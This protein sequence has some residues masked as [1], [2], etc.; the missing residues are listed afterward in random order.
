MVRNKNTESTMTGS[1]IETL[2]E[3]LHARQVPSNRPLVTLS[4][5][6]SLD[7]S[8]TVKPGRP[9]ALSGEHSLKL[10]HRLRAYH[11]GILIGIGTVL[12][13]NPRLDVRLVEG[14]DPQPI[15]MD[16]RLRTPLACN[17]LQS[18]RPAWIATLKRADPAR[19]IALQDAGA[20]ILRIPADKSKRIA[21]H[22][23]L[24]RLREWDIKTLMVEGG[25]QVISS[26]LSAGMVDMLVL[27]LAPQIVAGLRAVDH[28][29]LPAERETIHLQDP[30]WCQLG[31]DMIVWGE[32]AWGSA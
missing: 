22:A 23:L 14:N 17:L 9:L 3:Q 5:A 30:G 31:D 19:A 7:G 15:I 24:K 12:S 26:F 13:D 29:A 1:T 4:Y 25:A 21:P 8:L 6:Q 28:L 27:T 18:K 11:D 2:F 16:S 20:R 10:T 32:L